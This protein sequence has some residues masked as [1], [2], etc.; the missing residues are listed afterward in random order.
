M[1][2]WNKGQLL[3]GDMV[4]QRLRTTGQGLWKPTKWLPG[5]CECSDEKEQL[6]KQPITDK[7]RLANHIYAL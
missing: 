6:L 7:I 5:L 3:E 4:E 2:V 1:G